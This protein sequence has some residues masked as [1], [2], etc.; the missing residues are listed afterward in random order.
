MLSAL[1]CAVDSFGMAAG[2]RIWL[3]GRFRA[4]LAA[5]PVPEDAWRGG[6][7]KAVV[8]VL[9]LAPDHC[10]HREQVMDALWPD[11][12]PEA[13]AAN[14]RK[15]VHYA[16][17]ATSPRSVLSRGEVLVADAWVDVDAF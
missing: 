8:K 2:L 4:E 17:R 11:L 16:R 10:L 1:V 15:A 14:L 13:A 6:R 12:A 3:L 9:A 5:I 7:A